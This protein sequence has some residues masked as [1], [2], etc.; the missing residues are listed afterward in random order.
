MNESRNLRTHVFF[1]LEG[2]KYFLG[3]RRVLILSL[4][5]IM[6]VHFKELMPFISL[7]SIQFLIYIFSTYLTTYLLDRLSEKKK[8]P[9]DKFVYLQEMYISILRAKS[10]IP[11]WVRLF[12]SPLQCS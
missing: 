2:V 7:K 4:K 5:C 1:F 3:G 9:H 10:L 12:V 6:C 8:L 11:I